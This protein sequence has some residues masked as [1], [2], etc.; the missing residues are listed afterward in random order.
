MGTHDHQP[1]SSCV[2]ASETVLGAGDGA[3]LAY[4][5]VIPAVC[6]LDA[7]PDG[8]LPARATA[9]AACVELT[10]GLTRP[11]WRRLCAGLLWRYGG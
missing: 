1:S 3:F 10:M 6:F 2:G 7:N 5:A 8:Y 11:P 9:A 4:G